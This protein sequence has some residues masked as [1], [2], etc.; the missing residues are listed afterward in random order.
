MLKKRL[1]PLEPLIAFEAAARL[2]SFTRAG[3]ELHLSQAAISQQIR[4]LESSLQ[5]KLF[6]RSHRAVQLTNEGREYLHTVAAIL[7]QLA[8]ATMDIQNVEFSRQ[9]V[10]GCDQSFATQWLGPRIAQLRSALPE[11]ALRIIASDDYAESL[12][13]EVQV[14]VLH[15]DGQWPG[16][17]AL[18]LFDEEVFPVCSPDYPHELAGQ[19]WVSWLLQAQLIDLADSHWNWMNWRLWLGGNDI[20]APLGNRNLQFNSYPLVIDAACAAQGVALGWRYLVDE[21]IAEGR[22]LRPL[23]QSLR[24]EFGYYLISRENLLDDPVILRLQNWLTGTLGTA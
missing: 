3:E 7:K 6:S 13:A 17:R 14:A 1:P 24:T 16:F 9:L 23:Q 2:L 8:G 19:D 5:V 21:L 11:V 10:I 4:S 15:G 22:L 20:D 18:R 12:G